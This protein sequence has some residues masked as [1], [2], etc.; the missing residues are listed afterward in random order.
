MSSGPGFIRIAI[1]ELSLATR[2]AP[3]TV[4][5]TLQMTALE[6]CDVEDFA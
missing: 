3:N 1:L 6:P 5:T 4:N 2:L